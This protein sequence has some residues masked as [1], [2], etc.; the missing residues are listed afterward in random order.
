MEGVSTD[1]TIPST[2]GHTVSF[3]RGLQTALPLR[4]LIGC[5]DAGAVLLS[6][7]V[8]T[9]GVGLISLEAVE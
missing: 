7:A 2:E 1:S 5:P 8:Q 9:Q 3:E 6:Q 4:Q